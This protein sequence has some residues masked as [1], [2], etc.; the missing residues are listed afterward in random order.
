[1]SAG[2]YT[3]LITKEA[4]ITHTFTL[5]GW[6]AAFPVGTAFLFSFIHGA[7]ASNFLTVLGLE[8]KKS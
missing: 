3:M 1:M 6:Y 8:P 4:L 5:G 7:F 2:L